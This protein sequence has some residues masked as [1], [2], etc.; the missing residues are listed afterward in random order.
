MSR[1]KTRLGVLY[2][3]YGN[4]SQR[5]KFHQRAFHRPSLMEILSEADWD[6]VLTGTGLQQ[7]LLAL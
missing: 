3:A 1:D 5:L 7:S 6:V 4:G 2:H